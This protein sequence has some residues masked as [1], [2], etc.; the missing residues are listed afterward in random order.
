MLLFFS[1]GIDIEKL[2]A[3]FGSKQECGILQET[4]ASIAFCDA[5]DEFPDK[6]PP[7]MLKVFRIAQLTIQYLLHSQEML[8]QAVQQLNTDNGMAHRVSK[9]V[10]CKRMASQQKQNARSR[11][12]AQLAPIALSFSIGL[13]GSKNS[14]FTFICFRKWKNCRKSMPKQRNKS[15]HSRSNAS[16]ESKQLKLSR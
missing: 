11:L 6:M 2:T 13:L 9:E 12:E 14:S 8:T 10:R 1:A 5:R 3:N 4:L 16:A 15:K 7:E